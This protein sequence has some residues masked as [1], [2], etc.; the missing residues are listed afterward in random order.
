V[1]KDRR[2]TYYSGK[3]KR[4]TVKNQLIVNNQGII[5]HKLEHMKGRKHDYDIYETN[6]PI[7]PKEVV[8]IWTLDI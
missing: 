3:K 2:K 7:T 5:I 8:N 6:H 4:H 1:D